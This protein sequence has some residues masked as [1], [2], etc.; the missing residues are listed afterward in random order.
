MIASR[1]IAALRIALACAATLPC[2]ACLP[3]LDPALLETSGGCVGQSPNEIVDPGEQ[4]DDGNVVADDG[5]SAGCV[6]EC[7][8]WIDDLT[9]TCYL[10]IAR[11]TAATEAKDRC[12]GLAGKNAHVLTIHGDREQLLVSK[13]AASV[14]YEQV[15]AGLATG[16]RI[17]WTSLAPREPGWI[18]DGCPGCYAPWAGGVPDLGR[19]AIMDKAASWSWRAVE[20]NGVYDL[21]CER[22]RAGKPFNEC[23][24]PECDPVTTTELTWGDHRYRIVSS[25]VHYEAASNACAAWGGSLL[26]I[27]SVE[28]REMIVRFG[29]TPR[30][31]IGLTRAAGGGA[32]TWADGKNEADRKIPWGSLEAGA[33]ALWGVVVVSAEFD[34]GLVQPANNLVALPYVCRK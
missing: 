2:G 9:G 5:C 29:P 17:T 32:W 20:L 23:R 11:S 1:R 14:G 12:E 19:V 21:I 34:T 15:F 18:A 4:C 28:E 25:A 7:E 30:F 31:W 3:D 13:W 26:V 27:D 6:L 22:A 33:A 8:G 24:S 10:P 16:D